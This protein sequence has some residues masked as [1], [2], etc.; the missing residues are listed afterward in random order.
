MQ[1]VFVKRDIKG[2]H[3]KMK[4]RFRK[5]R[6]CKPNTYLFAQRLQSSY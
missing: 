5:E 6:V 1:N 3:G 4:P 2:S